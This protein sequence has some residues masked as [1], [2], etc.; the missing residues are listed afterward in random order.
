MNRKSNI[1]SDILKEMTR[2]RMRVT[3]ADETAKICYTI[4]GD[5]SIQKVV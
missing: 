1:E 5:V 2:Y 4:K 3:N